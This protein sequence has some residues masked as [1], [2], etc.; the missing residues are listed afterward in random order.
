MPFWITSIGLLAVTGLFLV[1]AMRRGHGN[2]VTAAAYDLQVYRDQLAEVDRDLARGVLSQ[3]D[4]ARVQVEISR[5]ILA[6][7]AQVQIESSGSEQNTSITRV[8]LAFGGALLLLGSFGIYQ[9]IGN[10]GYPDLGLADRKELARES[11]ANRPSQAAFE[12]QLPAS[13]PPDIDPDFAKLLEQLRTAVKERPNELRGFTLLARNEATVQNFKAA[14]IAQQRVIALKADDAS[15]FDYVQLADMMIRA[16]QSYVSPEAEVALRAAL[17]RDPNNGF[18]RYYS[19]LMMSQ[20][21]RPDMT[22]RNWRDLLET[23]PENAPWIAPIRARIDDLA[24][25]AGVDYTPPAA[26]GPSA[27]DVE[28]ADNLSA[29][30]RAEMI[31]GMVAGL[32]ERLGTEG[33]TPQEWAQLIGAYGVLG[34]LDKARIIWSEAQEVFAGSPE[35]LTAIRAAAE[36]AGLNN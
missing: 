15:S 13:A 28:A 19:G 6:A 33:G 29:E 14:Y 7:D 30:D 9:T 5:R 18:A 20:N 32:A 4:A 10:P 12:A 23:G 34:D 11:L 26:R 2:D 31:Q 17:E 1:T 24:W 25:I 22:F 21:G 27:E 16:A 36:R 3:E 8:G 35:A